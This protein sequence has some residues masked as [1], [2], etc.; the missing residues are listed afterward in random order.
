M[1]PYLDILNSLLFLLFLLFP[2]LSLNC[3]LRP[4][5]WPVLP[6]LLLLLLAPALPL[7]KVKNLQHSL[8]AVYTPWT[9]LISPLLP[10]HHLRRHRRTFLAYAVA[11][12]PGK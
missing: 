8:N 3:L 1:P 10:P 6:F 5:L 4:L 7:E 11:L 9:L 2:P 12:G